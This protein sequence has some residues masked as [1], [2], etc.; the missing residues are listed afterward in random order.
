MWDKMKYMTKMG[1]E[2]SFRKN[3]VEYMKKYFT[4]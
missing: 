4:Q 2:N 1:R 3:V